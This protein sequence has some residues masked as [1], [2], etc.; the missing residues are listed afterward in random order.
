[1]KNTQIVFKRIFSKELIDNLKNEK[2]FNDKL[3]QDI[4]NGNVFP[5]IRKN[6]IDFYYKGGRLFHYDKNGF[7]THIKYAAVILEPNKSYLNDKIDYTFKV[8]FLDHYERIKENCANYAGTESIGVSDL[9]H[10]FSYVFPKDIVVLDIELSL[11]S[12]E[13]GKK[14]DRIDILLFSNQS[15]ELHFVEAKYYSNSEIWSNTQAKVISQIERYNKQISTR[16]KDI[17]DAYY[18]YN[19]AVNNLFGLSLK[20]PLKVFQYVTLFIFGFDDDQKRHRL[21]TLILENASYK[22]KNIYNYCKGNTKK[23]DIKPL[24]NSKLL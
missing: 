11:E 5:A 19:I 23:M 14:S 10:Q 9:Y 20:A 8:N 12:L 21:N 3:L 1:M 24:W 7:E 13:E 18:N 17:L 22:N 15:Q 4:Q 2:L 6:Y 16:E